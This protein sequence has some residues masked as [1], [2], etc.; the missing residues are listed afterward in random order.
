MYTSLLDNFIEIAGDVLTDKSLTM[1]RESV[2][3]SIMSL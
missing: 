3:L 2:F 1:V